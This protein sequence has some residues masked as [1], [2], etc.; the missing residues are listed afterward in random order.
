M[1]LRN[2][3]EELESIRVQRMAL[4]RAARVKQEG[5]S[6]GVKGT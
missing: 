3:P 6:V 4:D 2:L 1:D 5:E